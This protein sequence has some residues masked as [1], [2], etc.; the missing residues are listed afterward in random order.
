MPDV[1]SPA[2]MMMCDTVQTLL[3]ARTKIVKA[4]PMAEG[5]FAR[6]KGRPWSDAQSDGRHG[7][8][9]IYSDGHMAW[10]QRKGGV[11]DAKTEKLAEPVV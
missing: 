3:R 4:V 7:Y 2:H 10:F 6:M 11:E 8:M 5:D 9:Y 1:K